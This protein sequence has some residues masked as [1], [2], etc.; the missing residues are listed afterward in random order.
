MQRVN[1]K[2]VIVTGGASGIGEADVR[3]LAEQGAQVVLADIDEEIGAKVA[4]R[5]GNVEF[6]RHDVR[7]E[8]DWERLIAG[9]LARYGRVDGLVNNAGIIRVG[10]PCTITLDALRAM[11]SVNLEG[12]VLGCKHA[13]PAMINSGGGSIVNIASI[14]AVS[15]LY[16]YG[17][18]C[19]SKGAVASYTRSVAAY[20]AVNKLGIR[21]NTVLPGGVDT[22]LVQG[23]EAEMALHMPDMRIP[24]S[25]PVQPDAPQM[26]SAV[27]EDIAH[28]VVYLISEESAFMNG[29]E[30]RIDNCASIIAAVVE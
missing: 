9:V 17:G 4:Q 8:T 6:V 1:G 11:M 5:T 30:I 23:L 16:F 3:L 28:A 14:G 24:P 29:G 27:P 10:D 21:C 12:T 20:C 18:Y 15:G 22:P 13:I 25:A 26:R 19:A 2:V 7:S